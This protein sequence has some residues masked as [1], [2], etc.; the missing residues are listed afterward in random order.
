MLLSPKAIDVLQAICPEQ[1]QLFDVHIQC[2]DGDVTEYKAINI[3]NYYDVSGHKKSVYAHLTDGR[4]CGYDWG[5]FVI[6]DQP[7]EPL[8]IARDTISH[9]TIIIS[10][11]LKKAL[12]KAKIRGCRYWPGDESKD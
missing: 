11:T 10:A 1:I 3:L 7:M 2:K 8:H 4:I 5:G 6:K 12:E 9:A